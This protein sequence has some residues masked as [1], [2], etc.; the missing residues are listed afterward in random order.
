MQQLS[1]GKWINEKN[2]NSTKSKSSKNIVKNEH[3]FNS[4]C[5]NFSQFLVKIIPVIN[6]VC[7]CVKKSF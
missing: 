2:I 5:L 6:W 4:T 1:P 7:A 3:E